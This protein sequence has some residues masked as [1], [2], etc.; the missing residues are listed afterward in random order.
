MGNQWFKFYGAEYL[1]DPKMDR[2]TVQERSC[3]LTLLCMASQ[4]DGIVKFLSPESI[5]TKSGIK[6][7]PYDTTEWDNAMSVLSTFEK[8][9][10]IKVHT[11]GDVEVVNWEKRQESY[12]TDAERARKYREKQR[13]FKIAS[14][15]RHG[16]SDERHARI[17]ENRI[18]ENT[19]EADASQ[20]LRYEVEENKPRTRKDTTY[21]KVF[22]LWGK[23]P[24][25]WKQ[26][27]TEIAAGQN[28]LAEHGLEK[29]A[30]ALRFAR[31]HADVPDCPQILKPSDLD[32]K[33]VNLLA[34]KG[35]V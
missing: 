5:L 19:S 23:Y 34:F 3:W 33:W 25:N 10:M 26:N 4:S 20:E 8:Y 18:E 17:E 6:F 1:S 32:R 28:I 9:K 35:R 2:L 11:N 16:P 27:R 14:Q 7:D 12:Q 22:E 15:K 30:N 13:E 24:L 31:E 29:A 21:L